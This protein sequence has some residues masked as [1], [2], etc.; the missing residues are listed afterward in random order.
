MI[1]DKREELI[2]DFMKL[3]N[4]GLVTIQ[5]NEN[6][7]YISVDIWPESQLLREETVLD[8]ACDFQL[9]YSIRITIDFLWPGKV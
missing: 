7:N 2:V 4:V 5:D 8:A 6:N 1:S 3:D 9:R